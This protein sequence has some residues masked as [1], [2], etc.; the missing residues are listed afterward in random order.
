MVSY[1]LYNDDIYDSNSILENVAKAFQS[2]EF[3]CV[4]YEDLVDIPKNYTSKVLR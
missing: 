3:F 2:D 1:F 4:L